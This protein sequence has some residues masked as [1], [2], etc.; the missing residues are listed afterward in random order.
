[1]VATSHPFV[2]VEPEEV[3]LSSARLENVTRVVHRAVDEGRVPGAMTLVGRRGK[4]AYC[5]AYGSADLEAGKA[6]ADATISRIYSV[7]RPMVSVGL[8]PLY[9]EGLFQ[10]DDPVSKYISSFKG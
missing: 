10:I 3:G 9:E 7:T 6:L 8:V 1:M 4:V 5:D 2:E